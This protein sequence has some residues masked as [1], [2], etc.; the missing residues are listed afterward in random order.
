MYKE[1]SR[2]ILYSGIESQHETIWNTLL[3]DRREHLYCPIPR[4][5]QISYKSNLESKSWT[6]ITS[7]GGMLLGW[8]TISWCE[9]LANKVVRWKKELEKSQVYV[10]FRVNHCNKLSSHDLEFKVSP[11]FLLVCNYKRNR[12]WTMRL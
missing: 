5:N 4:F 9:I 3:Q 1:C 2:W 12:S 7:E 10:L 8:D 11:V 6:W